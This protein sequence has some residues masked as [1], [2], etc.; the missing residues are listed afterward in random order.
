MAEFTTEPEVLGVSG[1]VDVAVVDDLLTR[2]RDLLSR[3]TGDLVLDLGEVTFIDSSGL[4][5]LVR[6]RKS[7]AEKGVSLRLVNVPAS[8]SRIFDLTGLSDLFFADDD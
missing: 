1:D 4:G 2:A 6:I 7:A 5:A 8:V 3:T